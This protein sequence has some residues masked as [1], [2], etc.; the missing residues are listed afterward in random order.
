VIIFVFGLLFG[1]ATAFPVGVQSFVV[2]NQ[3]LRFGYPRVLTG[4]ITASLCDTLLIVAGA[5]GASALLADADE[6]VPVLLI[7]IAFLAIFGVL[8]FRAPPEEEADEVKSVGRPLAMIAQ[9]VGVSLFNPHAVLETV[10]VLGGAIAAQTAENRIEFACGVIAASWVWFLMVGFGA[11][12]LQRRF[13]APAK[14]WMQRG[15]GVM[16]L[17]L[18]AVLVTRL[19]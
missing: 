4:I 9:T 1:L 13:T 8:A 15:S 17:A 5:A 16:M 3:G 6:R 2:M 18:A 11:S 12:A 10:G 19:A 14:L 7:G